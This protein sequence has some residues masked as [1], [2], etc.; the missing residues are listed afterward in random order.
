MTREIAGILKGRMAR[1]SVGQAEM[2]KYVG[3]DQSQLSKMIR[4][5]KPINIDQLEVMCIVLGIDF[6]EVIDEAWKQ[7]V[8]VSDWPDVPSLVLEGVRVTAA[9]YDEPTRIS[10]DEEHQLRRDELGLA[11]KRGLRKTDQ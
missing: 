6:D 3:V 10:D 8:N 9:V 11:A 4:G 7:V 5:I 2:A 1:F